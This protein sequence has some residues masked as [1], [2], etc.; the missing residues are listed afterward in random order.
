MVILTG[1]SDSEHMWNENVDYIDYST[2]SVDKLSSEDRILLENMDFQGG[3][4]ICVLS[5]E[6]VFI[7]LMQGM[8]Q[9][10]ESM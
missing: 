6:D 10:L 1:C 5:K 8:I 9:S 2:L 4:Y 3:K 7:Y